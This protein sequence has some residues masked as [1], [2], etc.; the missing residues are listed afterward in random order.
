[1]RP[2]EMGWSVLV[3]ESEASLR[4]ELTARFEEY[5]LVVTAVEEFDA[6]ERIIQDRRPMVFICDADCPGLHGRALE[7]VDAIR[8]H[9]EAH[10]V[11]ILTTRNTDYELMNAFEHGVDS[12]LFRPYEA[13]EALKIAKISA[14]IRHGKAMRRKHE[15]RWVSVPARVASL[16]QDLPRHMRVP[17][18]GVCRNLSQGGMLLE[19]TGRFVLGIGD[20]VSVELFCPNGDTIALT[21]SVVWIQLAY[22]GAGASIGLHFSNAEGVSDKLKQLVDAGVSSLH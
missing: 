12:V 14:Q 13:G 16:Q 18:S 4:S 20:E 7:L 22:A 8:A 1:M 5:G 9:S 11:I 19:T 2:V 3:V 10:P 6:A 15:R 17:I 21:A